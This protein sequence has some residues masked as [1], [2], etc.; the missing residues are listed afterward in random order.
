MK[1]F[2]KIFLY[3]V[4][5]II[6]FLLIDF[7]FDGKFIQSDL[8]HITNFYKKNSNQYNML[9]VGDSRTYCGI[10]PHL[11]D[12]RL[13]RHSINIASFAHWF[14]T[15]YPQIEE[16]LPFIPKNT[17]VV[18]SIGHQNFH[19]IADWRWAHNSA[20]FIGYRNIIKYITMG[21][22]VRVIINHLWRSSSFGKGLIW[23]KRN[24]IM[25]LN[26][27]MQP[28]RALK[29]PD[30]NKK[31]LTSPYA[32]FK[33]YNTDQEAVNLV[34]KWFR[35]PLKLRSEKNIDDGRLTAVT[36]KTKMGDYIRIELMP[37]YFRD[38]QR[39]WWKKNNNVNEKYKLDNSF[40]DLFVAT[41]DL[42][43]KNNIKVI[44]NEI[45]E[46][47]FFYD[48]KGF[49]TEGQD[50]LREKVRPYVEARGISY[51]RADF[52]QLDNSDYFDYNHLNSKGGQKYADL[53]S[54]EIYKTLIKNP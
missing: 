30:A 53:L 35:S 19:K 32:K 24:Y 2:I 29:K 54:N 44:V 38:K 6:P 28:V 40:W 33:K 11:M 52:S 1:K 14:P 31:R 15:Q 8:K 21:I 49:Y 18:W 7:Y 46:A 47:P 26:R 25:T 41:L 51:I 10:H 34:K 3:S 22:P 4:F 37:D 20:Y 12:A 27:I 43:Q 16:V 5:F 23:V 50:F 48:K 45:E 36:I 17:V 39:E 42:F 13:K 9:F